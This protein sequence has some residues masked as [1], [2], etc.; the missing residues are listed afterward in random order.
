MLA[1]FFELSDVTDHPRVRTELPLLRIGDKL[2]LR[3][4]LERQ[5]LNRR[6]ILDVS[7]EYQVTHLVI[8]L[9]QGRSRQIVQLSAM[10][11]AP[12]WKAVKRLP[13]RRLP[14]AVSP[15]TRIE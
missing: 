10:G 1:T 9:S 8:D 15:P 12:T 3:F 5:H 11:K 13:P 7:G 4:R 6:E 2:N 14:P